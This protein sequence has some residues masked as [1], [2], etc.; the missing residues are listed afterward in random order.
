MS[1]TRGLNIYG[2]RVEYA[3]VDEFKELVYTANVIHPLMFKTL[4]FKQRKLALNAI[5]LVSF[6]KT[7]IDE[8]VLVVFRGTIVY[9]LIRNKPSYA[10]YI[11]ATPNGTRLIYVKLDKVMYRCIR[12]ARLFYEHLATT[13]EEIGFKINLYDMCIANK[14]IDEK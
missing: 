9:L 4:T 1:A 5:T 8:Y 12:T 10:K 7:Q 11:H 2:E 3:I 6:L 14:L 13:L